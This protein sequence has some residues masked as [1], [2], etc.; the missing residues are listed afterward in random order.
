MNKFWRIRFLFL[1]SI[2]LPFVTIAFL[3]WWLSAPITIVFLFVFIATV[4]KAIEY[5]KEEKKEKN[6]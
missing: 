1:V 2:F 4:I 6:T 5:I 3:P